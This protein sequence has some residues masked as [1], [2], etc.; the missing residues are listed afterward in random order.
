MLIAARH[1][2][3]K[4]QQNSLH[5]L[6]GCCTGVNNP[7]NPCLLPSSKVQVSAKLDWQQNQRS[8]LALWYVRWVS[9]VT[10][11]LCAKHSSRKF[12][13]LNKPYNVSFLIYGNSSI[14]VSK[15]VENEASTWLTKTPM[16]LV[17]VPGFT[18]APSFW[19]HMPTHTDPRR[20]QWC[21]SDWTAVT[22]ETCLLLGSAP[23]GTISDIWRCS[24]PGK[25]VK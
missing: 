16:F 8:N 10:S 20:P 21:L 14:S 6:H 17:G 24:L 19:L 1:E 25:W 3:G 7:S 5:F 12:P 13:I 2:S 18:S 9:K 23:K 4:S 11:Y 22:R 15:M